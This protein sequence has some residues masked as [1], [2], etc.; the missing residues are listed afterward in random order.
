MVNLRFQQITYTCF[1]CNHRMKTT[2]GKIVRKK[3]TR[4]SNCKVDINLHLKFSTQNYNL[5]YVEDH[6]K[7]MNI[8]SAFQN[9]LN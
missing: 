5:P 6:K 9:R 8:R 1:L 7:L 4:C 3:S 2:L